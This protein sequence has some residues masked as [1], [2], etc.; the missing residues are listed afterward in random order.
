MQSEAPDKVQRKSTVTS[1]KEKLPKV[2]D[3]VEPEK[4]V[5]TRQKKTEKVNENL[6]ENTSVKDLIYTAKITTGDS[7]IMCFDMMITLTPV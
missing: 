1:E 3:K 2:K 6:L 4:K 5:T 7:K